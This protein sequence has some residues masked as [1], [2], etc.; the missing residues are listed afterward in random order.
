M[1]DKSSS[2]YLS[3]DLF[4]SIAITASSYALKSVF[5]RK[6]FLALYVFEE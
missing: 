1:I 3:F 6:L 5:E 2:L 4:L